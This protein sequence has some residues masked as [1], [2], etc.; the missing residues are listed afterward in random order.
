MDDQEGITRTWQHGVWEA[1]RGAVWTD[2]RRTC[3]WCFIDGYMYTYYFRFRSC[4]RRESL[5]FLCFSLPWEE[6]GEILGMSGRPFGSLTGRLCA[7]N[8]EGRRKS[9][10]NQCLGLCAIWV[11]A[12]VLVA[13]GSRSWVSNTLTNKYICTLSD[14]VGRQAM[15]V[16]QLPS[17][18]VNAILPTS[19]TTLEIE[20]Q[21]CEFLVAVWNMC[22]SPQQLDC[23]AKFD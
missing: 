8:R 15:L 6:M 23:R 1:E 2:G 3:G 17:R 14:T 7:A 11:L 20:V 13:R 10:H 16:T 18:C 21:C 5:Y 19:R 4:W 9:F 12:S 22:F